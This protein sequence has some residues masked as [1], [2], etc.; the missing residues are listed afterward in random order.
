M[1][2][3]LSIMS[4]L[5]TFAV[6]GFIYLLVVSVKSVHRQDI[7]IM[8]SI[9]SIFLFLTFSCDKRHQERW[10]KHDQ[11][12]KQ[13]LPDIWHGFYLSLKSIDI[14]SRQYALEEFLNTHSELPTLT[15][16][17]VSQ[18]LKLSWGSRSSEKSALKMLFRYVKA[19]SE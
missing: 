5:S 7:F 12:L 18:F 14:S 8:L 1:S 13:T 17:N 19:E 15:G 3:E 2:F 6:F 10:K 16:D 11:H 9:L 4:I